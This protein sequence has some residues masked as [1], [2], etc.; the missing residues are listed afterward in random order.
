MATYPTTSPL[1]TE[2]LNARLAAAHARPVGPTRE[3]AVTELALAAIARRDRPPRPEVRY[4]EFDWSPNGGLDAH[5]F[6]DAHGREV[7]LPGLAGD[8]AP[9][10]HRP[11]L[12]GPG[13]L[14]PISAHHGPF[15]LACPPTR[16]GR[17]RR[18]PR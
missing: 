7:P 14:I 18:L 10:E 1:T 11:A 9:V 2:Q 6:L 16:H 8:L 4:I 12:P 3:R 15:L 17:S 5:A 13:H